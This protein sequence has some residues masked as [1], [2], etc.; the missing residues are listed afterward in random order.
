MEEKTG[1]HREGE[2]SLKGEKERQK[3]EEKEVKSRA[4]DEKK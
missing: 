4:L 3:N 2:M 1:R